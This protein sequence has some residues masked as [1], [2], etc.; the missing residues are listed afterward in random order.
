MVSLSV[1]DPSWLGICWV[2][3]TGELPF[4]VSELDKKHTVEREKEGMSLGFV[5]V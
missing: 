1:S 3:E 4:L 5:E 2:I